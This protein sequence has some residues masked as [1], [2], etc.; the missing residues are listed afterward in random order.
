[1]SEATKTYAVSAESMQKLADADAVLADMAISA[2]LTGD[3]ELFNRIT[4]VG[5]PL[6][7]FQQELVDRG[8]AAERLDRS[9]R[10]AVNEL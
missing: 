8:L 1:M 6:Y 2:M 4:D 3:N 10:E 9:D 7:E 5:L